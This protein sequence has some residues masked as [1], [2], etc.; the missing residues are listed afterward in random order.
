MGQQRDYYQI[1][2]LPDTASPDEIRKAYFILAKKFHD[3]L[4]RSASAE[5]RAFCENALKDINAA[6]EVL[7]KPPQREA[8][9]RGRSRGPSS[10]PGYGAPRSAGSRPIPRADP[11]R[12]S[13]G[14]L[15]P[16]ELR[17]FSFTLSND[18]S[19]ARSCRVSAARFPW[20]ELP[21]EIDPLPA[22][23]PVQV[24]VASS[25]SKG[26]LSGAIRID[27]D[28]S[29][30]EVPVTGQVETLQ[31]T[32][33]PIQAGESL[34]VDRSIQV[35]QRKP[36]QKTACPFCGYQNPVGVSICRQCE[37]PMQRDGLRCPYCG[38]RLPSSACTCPGCRR[39]VT[40]W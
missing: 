3:D 10:D 12:I 11:N 30:I 23:V 24:Q 28:G 20:I 16:G 27:L 37:M 2:F 35:G 8:Y 1:L 26:P 39:L 5:E 21:F 13:L 7:S 15:R 4:N 22:R 25:T 9:D 33:A 34:V 31:T 29:V 14:I 19:P 38:E 36:V 6:Y 40:L 32:T 18:G 17:K